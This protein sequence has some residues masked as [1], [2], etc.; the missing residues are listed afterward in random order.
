MI[1]TLLGI[2][3][4]GIIIGLA[5]L[6]GLFFLGWVIGEPGEGLFIGLIFGCLFFLAVVGFLLLLLKFH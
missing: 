2:C 1:E 4:L 3:G 6:V 5:V